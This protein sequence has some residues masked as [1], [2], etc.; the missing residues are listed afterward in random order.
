[1]VDRIAALMGQE[2]AST[3]MTRAAQMLGHPDALSQMGGKDDKFSFSTLLSE[4]IDGVHK[5]QTASKAM[6]Q[7]Y[8]SGDP[9]VGIE[10]TM[11][12]MNKASLSVQMLAQ[13][14]NKVVAA[15]NDVMNMPV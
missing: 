1:M 10:E 9:T 14:R 2:T 12:A 8:Q 5:S 13:A 11:V 3:G 4:A 6:Q 7:A 15:Y